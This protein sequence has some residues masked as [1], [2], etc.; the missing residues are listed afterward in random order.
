MK[1]WLV[2]E[3][4]DDI[5]N[6]V[7]VM[8]GAWGHEAL[9][10]RD[11]NEIW[12]WLDRVEEG[13]H[14][15]RLPALALLDIRMPGYKGHEIA[16]RMRALKPFRQIPIVLMTAFSLT[17]NERHNMLN[18]C[19]VDHIINKPLP[20]FFEMKQLLEDLQQQKQKAASAAPDQANSGRV[21][22]GQTAGQRPANNG[23]SHPA[24]PVPGAPANGE[25]ST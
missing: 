22:A 24:K 4:E 15:E 11:G 1:P 20:D 25:Q 17:E 7:K 13:E 2:V 3:D 14:D 16:R 21:S 23:A 6:I 12:R 5:R 19:G 9:E 18:N 8:F 10:F